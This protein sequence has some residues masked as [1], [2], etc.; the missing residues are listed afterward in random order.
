MIRVAASH[1]PVRRD[2]ST[3]VSVAKK[4]VIERIEQSGKKNYGRP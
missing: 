4:T 2:K 1:E 3:P